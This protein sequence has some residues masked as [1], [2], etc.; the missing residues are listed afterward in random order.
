MREL[1]GRTLAGA[2]EG[3]QFVQAFVGADFV[4]A[5]GN[6]VAG[7]LAAGDEG[8]LD[9]G[10]IDDGVA[11]KGGVGKTTVS[12]ALACA[13]ARRG[14]RVLFVELDGKPVPPIDRS[15]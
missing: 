13:A 2:Q 8:H 3:V 7:E 10:E 14:L 5:L 1:L 6:F 11:G 4:E 9:G 15:T 12:A